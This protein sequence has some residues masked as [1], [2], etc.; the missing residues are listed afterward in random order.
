M[1]KSVKE[2]EEFAV[3]ILSHGRADRVKTYSTLKKQNY[4]GKIYIIIDDEDATIDEYKKRFKDE[5]IVFN[6]QA[7]IDMT[8]SADALKK[9][10]S[11]VYARNYAYKIAE[12]LKLN[13]FLVLD[14]DYL[15]FYNCFNN[16]RQYITNRVRIRNLDNYICAMIRF[17][18]HSNI[19]CVAMS[20]CGDYIG[21]ANSLIARMHTQRRM[22]RKAMNAF[23][24]RTNRPLKFSG[25]INE[26]VNMYITEGSVGKVMFTYPR[27]RL[28]QM[29]TQSNKGGL[30][31]IYL[32]LGTYV[33]SFY[34]ILHRPSCVRL[35]KMG[36]TNKRIHHK[37]L[38]KHA[39][40]MIVSEIHKK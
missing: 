29:P 23:F 35:M 9:R 13:Y 24:L 27:I 38:W 1:H 14:D 22:S 8:D 33:K 21:G 6:K 5:V 20:Q 26:D 18:K 10:N 19:D 39:V 4:T 3:L 25:R 32:D 36:V 2:Y 28:K 7:A 34:S 15:V 11:V 30:T 37:I 40:P 12:Q 17:L 31:D 16:H